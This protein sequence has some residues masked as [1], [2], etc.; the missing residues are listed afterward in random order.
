MKD[1]AEDRLAPGLYMVATPIGNLEDLSFRALRTLKQ[2]D[3]IAAEDTRETKK[4]LNAYDL[5]TATVSLHEHSGP[6]KVAE[7][8]ERLKTGGTGAYVSDAGTPGI[9]D[10]GAELAAAARAA[11]I[12]VYPVPGASAPVALLSIAGFNETAFAFHGFFP[13]ENAARK[14]WLEKASLGGVHVFFESPY[15]IVETL[16]FLEKEK[17]EAELIVGRELT[18]KFETVTA[19]NAGAVAEILRKEEGR[20]E[21]VIG[22]KLPVPPP[23]SEEDLAEKTSILLREL[24]EL[25]GNQKLLTRVAMSHG[26][27]K[28]RAYA[29]SLEILKKP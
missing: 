23:E 19:G 10:P 12:S 16:L 26:L 27:P 25:G 8:V 18:K 2:A 21:Y 20:G 14:E 3:W 6:R 28:N 13:R 7:L 4:L 29:L 1:Q 9:S 24:A 15:R 17:P 22:L 11:G 5:V